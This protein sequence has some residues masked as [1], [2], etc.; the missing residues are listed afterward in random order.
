MKTQ[1]RA[2]RAKP[3]LVT[4][5]TRPAVSPS[6]VAV[7]LSDLETK[8]GWTAGSWQ[9]QLL[10]AADAG[11]TGSVSAQQISAYLENPT[12]AKFVTST[13]MDKLIADV[14]A[15]KSIAS[16]PTGWE[17]TVAK[18]AD[19]NKDGTLTAAELTGYLQTVKST[20]SSAGTLWL[21][22]QKA[23]AFES[24]VK[25]LTGEADLMRGNNL[26]GTELPREYMRIIEDDPHR[27]ANMV[28]YTLTA[29][30][31]HQT[32]SNVS[33]KNNFHADPA[34]KNSST[35]TDYDNSGFDRGHQKPAEDSPN[36]E[37]MNE[38]FLMTNMAPQ[39][40]VLNEQSWKYLEEATR[41]LVNATGGTA[42]IVTGSLYVDANMQPLPDAQIQWIGEKGQK[43]V[44]VPTHSFKTVILQKPDGTTQAY[45]F[46]VP[47]RND[48]PSKAKDIQ[49]LLQTCR[50]PIGGVEKALTGNA[51]L[52]AGL[53]PALATT[54]KADSKMAIQVPDP[55]APPR[56]RDGLPT[57]LVRQDGQLRD[58]SRRSAA[59]R[60]SRPLQPGR[61]HHEERRLSRSKT[62]V[63]GSPR[64]LSRQRL[65]TGSTA[66]AH[67]K[68]SP[69]G[70]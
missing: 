56:R 58:V 49:A 60:G 2:P 38:T 52:Y 20:T 43:R 55:Q 29:S 11:K 68:L 14:G 63:S 62:A 21:P 16:L 35:P 19:Q 30:D 18:A 54:L 61:E 12:D 45:A 36:M 6:A 41:E 10:R 1:T 22:D 48:L 69:P 53:P 40:K 32:L 23:A 25:D 65:S 33:R 9:D 5:P 64:R 42:T 27:T 15:S 17:Q 46:V 31:Q 47:N 3:N 67:P 66:T 28:S 51:Q 57:R 4:K 50:S 8:F 59:R 37:A 24:T 26:V 7:K 13:N 34:Y 44:A 39:T 70:A